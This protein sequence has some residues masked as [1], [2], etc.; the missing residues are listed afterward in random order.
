MNPALAAEGCF[1]PKSDIFR[2][3][4]SYPSTQLI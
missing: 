2:S 4:Y 1:L 3:L